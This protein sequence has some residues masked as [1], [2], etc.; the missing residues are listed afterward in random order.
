MS[1]PFS[2]NKKIKTMTTN[3]KK[4]NLKDLRKNT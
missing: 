4:V 2:E 1:K 3:N